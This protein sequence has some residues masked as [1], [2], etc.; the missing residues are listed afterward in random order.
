MKFEERLNAL[1]SEVEVPDELSPQNIAAMLKAETK[2]S[3]VRADKKNIRM[4]ANASAQR[5]TIMI[6]TAAAAAACT[7]YA[8]GML[9]THRV[10][11]GISGFL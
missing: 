1:I 11:G 5:R 7:V 8:A 2:Q 6:R 9:R 10:R 3:H 4:S